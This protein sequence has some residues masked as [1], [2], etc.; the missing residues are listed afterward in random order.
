M[1][2]TASTDMPDAQKDCQTRQYWRTIFDSTP[3]PT[4]IVDADMR[5]QDCNLA[6]AQLLGPQP[7]LVLRQRGGEA[8]G[9]IH[10]EANGCGHGP[11]CHDC[12]LR[13]SVKQALDGGRTN[14]RTHKGELRSRDRTVAVDLLI[15]ATPLPGGD[16]PQVLLLLEDV[17]ELST[18]R[19]LIPICA[20]CKKVRDDQQYWQSL[21]GYLAKQTNLKLTHGICPTCF[22]KQMKDF[23][24]VRKRPCPMPSPVP[25]VQSSSPSIE[26]N[27]GERK[28][29]REAALPSIPR[30]N[31]GA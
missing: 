3:I 26:S 8:W 23:E 29:L 24:A 4:F 10:A 16:V 9:C 17:S 7:E 25:A 20:Q 14:R 15:T 21:E 22:A 18:L 11:N 5:I 30:Q 2:I 13:T 6:A 19:G 28:G 31:A 1:M 12:V 27:C